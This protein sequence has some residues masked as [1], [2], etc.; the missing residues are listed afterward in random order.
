MRRRLVTVRLGRQGSRPPGTT[1]WVRGARC[2]RSGCPPKRKQRGVAGREARPR[3]PK[4]ATVE[5]R[6]ASV[7]R[8]GT[9]GAS[10][11]PG[12][13]RYCVPNGCLAN[14][15][16]SLGAPPTP[17]WVSEAK[18]QK[19]GRRN[20]PRERD[21]LFDIVRWNYRKRFGDEPRVR[22]A[23]GRLI[24]RS[25]RAEALP[26]IRSCVRASRRMGRRYP[27]CF[28]THRS[29]AE[30]WMHSSSPGLRCSSA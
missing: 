9:Q 16:T 5:R 26:Q 25:A 15:R 6:E 20:A 12:T 21:G 19:P 29:A 4:T 11:A 23:L 24:L 22:Y 3:E 17:H 7:P 2:D 1:T 13:L 27:S 30:L 8:H 14:T 18:R 28:E 10:Q